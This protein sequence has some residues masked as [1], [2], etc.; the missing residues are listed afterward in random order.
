MKFRQ[1]MPAIVALVAV[2]TPQAVVAQP[3][4]DRQLA[5]FVKRLNTGLPR[6]LGRGVWMNAV[7]LQGRT[8][9]I[10][11]SGLPDWRPTRQEADV[12]RA[13]DPLCLDRRMQDLINAGLDVVIAASSPEGAELPLIRLCQ[14]RR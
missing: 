6:D 10:R 14:L 1:I 5:E 8:L 3:I 13:F 2:S 7:T 11:A 12:K 4:S 9:V